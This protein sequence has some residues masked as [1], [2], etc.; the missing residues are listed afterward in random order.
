[1]Q[2]FDVESKTWKSLKSLAPA[3]QVTVC[4]CALTVGTKLFVSS[5]YEIYSYNIEGNVWEKLAPPAGGPVRNLCTVGDYMYAKSPKTRF[6]KNILERYSYANQE[7][8]SVSQLNITG[9]CYFSGATELRSKVYVLYGRKLTTGSSSV[10]LTAVLH[11]FD[12]NRNVW[13]EKAATCDS[14][15]GSSLFVVNNRVHVA[16]GCKSVDGNKPCGAPA[17]VEVYD[18]ET[19]KWSVVDQKHIPPN[20]LGAVEIESKIYFIINKFPFDSGI[21]IPPGELYHVSLAKWKNLSNIS[22]KAALC[23]MPVKTETLKTE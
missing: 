23:Y 4:H 6:S 19:N 9:D 17:P 15:V 18:E 5:G 12:S 13:E 1:M 16:G 11:C 14:H 21:R 20:N 7:W 3:P 2:Y 8:Q 22:D 10:M